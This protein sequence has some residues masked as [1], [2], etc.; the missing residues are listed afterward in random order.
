MKRP[1]QELVT[2]LGRELDFPYGVFLMTGT[3]IVPPDAFTLHPGDEV[4]ITIDSLIL[5]NKVQS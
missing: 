4:R 5:E 3:G 2:F 1:L